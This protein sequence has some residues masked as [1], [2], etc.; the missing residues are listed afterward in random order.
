MVRTGTEWIPCDERLPERGGDTPKYSDDYRVTVE[1][2]NGL[3]FVTKGYYCLMNGL[4]YRTSNDAPL[5]GVIA[6]RGFV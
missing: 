1:G 6:W 2:E 5:P 3:P 4:W